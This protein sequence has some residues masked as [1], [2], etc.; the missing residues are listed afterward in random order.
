MHKKLKI[1]DFQNPTFG[2]FQG[3]KVVE[4]SLYQKKILAWNLLMYIGSRYHSRFF[5][6][7]G[8]E[9]TYAAI[10][11]NHFFTKTCNPQTYQNY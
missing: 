7:V 10:G 8:R 2:T 4:N 9:T 3:P 11:N 6:Q 5:V 1:I